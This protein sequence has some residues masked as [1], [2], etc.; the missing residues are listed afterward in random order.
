MFNKNYLAALVATAGLLFVSTAANA[1]TFTLDD[2]SKTVVQPTSGM[3]QVDFTGTVTLTQGYS[4]GVATASQLWNAAGDQ[5]YGMFAYGTFNYTG[6]IFS[7]YFDATDLGLYAF[8]SSLVAP[9]FYTLSECA[10]NNGVCTDATVNYSVNVV[11]AET[12][13]PEPA[14][15]TL[16]GAGLL[17]LAF[18]ARRS[19][20]A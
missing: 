11:K 14:S 18:T 19:R 2:Y 7:L 10:P 4:Y 6:V 13:V 15:F 5:S 12:S 3:V 9:A 1:I 16:L 17:G 8:D 20:R